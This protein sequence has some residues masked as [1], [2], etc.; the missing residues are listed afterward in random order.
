MKQYTFACKRMCFN[1]DIM[2]SAP[3]EDDNKKL[4]VVRQKTASLGSTKGNL[5]QN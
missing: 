4:G 2:I 3:V 5:K 1:A